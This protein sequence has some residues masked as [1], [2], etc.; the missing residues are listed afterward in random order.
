MPSYTHDFKLEINGEDVAYEV[1][2]C[3]HMH[4]K[5]T[6]GAELTFKQSETILQLLEVIQRLCGCSDSV[7]SIEF[8]EK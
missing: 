3:P 2:T 6:N 8:T 1:T 7:T 4:I 5:P